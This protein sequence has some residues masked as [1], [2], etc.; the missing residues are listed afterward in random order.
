MDEH[1]LRETE[2]F[3]FVQRTAMDRRTTMREVARGVVDRSIV[4]S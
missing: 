4:P 2:A 1:G 3:G